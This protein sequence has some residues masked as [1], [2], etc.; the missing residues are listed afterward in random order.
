MVLMSASIASTSAAVWVLFTIQ[1]T[2]PSKTQ[3]RIRKRVANSAADRKLSVLNT[4]VGRKEF[5]SGAA[6]R[7]NHVE[8]K[9]MIDFAAQPADVAFDHAGLRIEMNSPHIFQQHAPREHPI[10][11]SREILQQAKFLR[12]QLNVLPGAHDGSLQ[13]VQLDRS[14]AQPGRRLLRVARP[15]RKHPDPRQQFRERKRLDQVIVAARLQSLY[16]IIDPPHGG[17]VYHRRRDRLLA[18]FPHEI[19][20]IQP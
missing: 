7:L 11:I 15:A 10:R 18:Y 13:Q 12:Q 6:D 9:A 14:H 2:T 16:P 8:F 19:Q 5:I 20:P 1:Y 3:E 4:L 17:E